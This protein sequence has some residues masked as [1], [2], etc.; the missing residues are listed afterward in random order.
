MCSGVQ[1]MAG[2]QRLLPARWPLTGARAGRAGMKARASVQYV[3]ELSN[4][5]WNVIR[6]DD[7]PDHPDLAAYGGLPWDDMP[8]RSPHRLT[9]YPG[10][11]SEEQAAEAAQLMASAPLLEK[12]EGWYQ[13]VETFVEKLCLRDRC[14]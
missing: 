7:T 6:R 9:G 8:A 4:G 2:A 11:L 14:P 12:R 1:P 3:V 13:V 10:R 5:R